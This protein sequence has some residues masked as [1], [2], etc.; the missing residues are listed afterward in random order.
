M[1]FYGFPAATDEGEDHFGAPCGRLA[2]FRETTAKS[3]TLL[4]YLISVEFGQNATFTDKEKILSLGSATQIGTRVEARVRQSRYDRADRQERT[5]MRWLRMAVI[6]ALG[7]VPA[8][9]FVAKDWLIEPADAAFPYQTVT[10]KGTDSAEMIVLTREGDA[11][12]AADGQDKIQFRFQLVRDDYYLLQMGPADPGEDGTLLAL[13]HLDT[14]TGAIDL[15]KTVGRADD[16]GP[17]LEECN[18]EICVT[19]LSAFAELAMASAERG[20]TPQAQYKIVS[21]K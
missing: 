11:Y 15:Y 8:G 20:E 9:C 13:L 16:A 3:L 7:F 19:S 2:T 17:G 14:A 5:M 6:V 21:A 18:Q 4:G 12:V 1:L 10:V